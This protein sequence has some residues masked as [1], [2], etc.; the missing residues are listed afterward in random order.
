MKLQLDELEAFVAV[1]QMG[2]FAA[3][4]M[5]INL[6]QPAITRRVQKLESTLGVQLIVRTAR[7][8]H[9]T[10]VGRE[11]FA[12][13]KVILGDLEGSILGIREMAERVTGE[14]TIGAVPTATSYFLP[15]VIAEYNRIYPKIRIRI[16]DLSANDVLT[17]VKN[18]QADFGINMVGGQEPEI[19]FDPLL[20]DP[21]V[22]VCRQDHALAQK[23]EVRW[24]DITPF[25]FT[26]VGL[27]S[28]NRIVMESALANVPGRPRWF[29]E[30]Q[31]LTTSLG[32]VEEGLGVA[33]VPRMAVTTRPNNLLVT[34]PLIDPVVTRVMGIITR[35]GASLTRA[36][37]AFYDMLKERSSRRQG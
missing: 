14:V 6:S 18:G 21:F 33:A 19:E 7:P 20:E 24:V 3:A 31:H 32:L 8:L 10:P 9:L 22:L 11:F 27:L 37:Q 28:G 1:A 2:S 13:T 15:S 25:R 12:K 36:A 23:P 34:R 5:H 26:T 29:Y 16:L 17:A 30:V 35:R 4:A